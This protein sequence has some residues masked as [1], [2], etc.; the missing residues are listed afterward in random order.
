MLLKS[1]LGALVGF[2]CLAFFN[3]SASADDH[4]YTEGPVVSVSSIRTADGK[5]D[6]YMKFVDTNWKQQQEAA[7]SAGNVLSYQV[8]N[9]IPRGPD[10][11]D[12]LL[13]V[14]YKNWAA[15]LDGALARND[16]ISKE[17]DGSVSSTNQG[18]ANRAQIR[19]LLGTTWMQALNLK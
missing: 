19:R 3:V 16:A 6:D 17:V 8:L 11:P 14:T 4:A 13:V 12:L 2:A 18:V 7:K 1:R 10:D 15:G 5:F 9:V